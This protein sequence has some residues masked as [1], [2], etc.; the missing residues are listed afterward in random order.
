MSLILEVLNLGSK[1][2][3]Q[4]INES[5]EIVYRFVPISAAPNFDHIL[6]GFYDLQIVK[7]FLK[8]THFEILVLR[9]NSGK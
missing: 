2:E 9:P 8:T 6:K 7:N 1:N 3:L 5:L 4:N